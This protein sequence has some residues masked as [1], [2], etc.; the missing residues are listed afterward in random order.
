MIRAFAWAAALI[1]APVVASAQPAELDGRELFHHK[2]GMCHEP[3]GM[4]AG[5]LAR[6]IQPAELEKRS[7]LS[8]DYVFR[9]ARG[10]LGNMPP[11]PPGDVSDTQLKAIAAY[12]AAGPHGGR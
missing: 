6:R 5:L 3:G 9:Y 10:G 11:I 2:C 8:P 1:A 12:L 7:N 4:G